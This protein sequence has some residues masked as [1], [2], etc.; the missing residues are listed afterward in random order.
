MVST[1]GLCGFVGF[2]TNDFFNYAKRA[3]GLFKKNIDCF[4]WLKRKIP[5]FRIGSLQSEKNTKC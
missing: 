5:F 1:I 2:L 3:S 4:A